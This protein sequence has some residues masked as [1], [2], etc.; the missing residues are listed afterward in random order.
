MFDRCIFSLIPAFSTSA[1]APTLPS[2]LDKIL[3][4]RSLATLGFSIIYC[5]SAV[6]VGVHDVCVHFPGA[7]RLKG[8]GREMG[9]TFSVTKLQVWS[10]SCG[11]IGEQ[12]QV[13]RGQYEQ[14]CWCPHDITHIS[15]SRDFERKRKCTQTVSH[16]YRMYCTHQL[17]KKVSMSVY[18][19]LPQEQPRLRGGAR[20]CSGRL[21]KPKKTKR[22]CCRLSR[23][24]TEP[25]RKL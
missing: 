10:L 23:R 13:V 14:Q 17:P 3:Y 12:N 21:T 7:D 19:L 25:W 11:S 20:T 18:V 5:V 9:P 15:D 2:H 1:A 6:L 16:Y 24:Q 8:G 4:S 22:S